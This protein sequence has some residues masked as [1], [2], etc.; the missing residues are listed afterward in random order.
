M[1]IALKQQLEAANP[2]V[3]GRSYMVERNRT[4]VN[5][6]TG[7]KTVKTVQ[8][9]LRKWYWRD[10]EGKLRFCL[11]VGN[12]RLDLDQGRS[13]QPEAEE[14]PGREASGRNPYERHQDHG[15]LNTGWGA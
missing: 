3:E 8:V 1:A 11:R 7:E 12:K 13:R 2:M 6:E 10:V 9:P 4:E 15:I 5:E 14:G